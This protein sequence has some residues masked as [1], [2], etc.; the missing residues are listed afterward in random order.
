MPTPRLRLALAL[1]L[2]LGLP[3]LAADA[4]VGLLP[5]AELDLIPAAPEAPAV[6]PDLLAAGPDGQLALWN[7]AEALLHLYPS[8]DAAL[9]GDPGSTFALAAAEDLAWTGVGLLVLDGRRISLYAASGQRLSERELPGLVPTGVRLVVEDAAIYGAD[10]FGN[11]HPVATLAGATLRAPKSQALLPPAAAVR[12]DEPAR[13]LRVGMTAV[14][15]PD[16]MKAGGRVLLGG[17]QR[18]LVVD[19]VVGDS[20]LQVERQ[21]ISLDTGARVSLPVSGRL[22]APTADVAVDGRGALVWMAP[23]AEGLRLGEVLP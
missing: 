17:G 18:W 9:A 13:T 5:W 7:P 22:Y 2:L 3:A 15:M 19:A 21:V 14:K 8:V 16:A 12:W 4:R 10:V 23:Q 6:G 1:S 11:R 20:P